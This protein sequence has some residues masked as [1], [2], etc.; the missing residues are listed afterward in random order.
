MQVRILTSELADGSI[1]Y[2]VYSQYGTES[3]YYIILSVVTNACAQ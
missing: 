2:F 3:G 1:G